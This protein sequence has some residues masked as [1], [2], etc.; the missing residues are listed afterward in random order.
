MKHLNCSPVEFSN[1]FQNSGSTHRPARRFP[2]VLQQQTFHGK[3]LSARKFCW[4]CLTTSASR[5]LLNVYGTCCS[6]LSFISNGT[7]FCEENEALLYCTIPYHMIPYHTIP[8]HIIPYYTIQYHTIPYYTIQYHTIPYHI[9]PYHTI[10]YH[11]IPYHTIPYH[12]IPYHTIP[13]HTIP[14]SAASPMI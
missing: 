4:M 7:R 2:V 6:A 9:I 13:Y 1:I 12:T 10:P 3:V 11:T 8:Y 14:S 5:H